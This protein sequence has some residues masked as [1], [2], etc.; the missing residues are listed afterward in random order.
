[1]CRDL[2]HPA[3]AYIEQVFCTSEVGGA[4]SFADLTDEYPA[5]VEVSL[6]QVQQCNPTVYQIIR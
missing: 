6:Q 5:F 4:I 2:P 1:M 3:D